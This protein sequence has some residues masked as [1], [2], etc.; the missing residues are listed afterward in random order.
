MVCRQRGGK[1]ES[2]CQTSQTKRRPQK[3]RAKP[4]RSRRSLLKMPDSRHPICARHSKFRVNVAVETCTPARSCPTAVRIHPGPPETLR[5]FERKSCKSILLGGHCRFTA[6]PGHR[7]VDRGALLLP[8]M[9]SV[10]FRR[11]LRAV[12]SFRL[13]ERARRA[14]GSN[15]VSSVSS[16]RNRSTSSSLLNSAR[17]HFRMR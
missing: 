7:F 4:K 8:L 1:G 5:N 11:F 9:V 15:R 10:T 13:D 2:K 17:E 16:C 12:N 14:A 6:T 3:R